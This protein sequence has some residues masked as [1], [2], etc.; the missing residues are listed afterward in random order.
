MNINP[1][2]ALR[3]QSMLTEFL[4]QRGLVLAQ[5]LAEMT[6]ERDQ[7]KAEL[8]ALRNERAEENADGA[9]E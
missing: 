4:R 8:E 1:E 3:E 5:M 9:A 6:S 7:Y 2:I